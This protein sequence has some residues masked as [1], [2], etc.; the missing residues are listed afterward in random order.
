MSKKLLFGRT[1]KILLFVTL[2]F[3]VA[4]SGVFAQSV[5]PGDIVISE[6]MADPN[7]TN[8]S[9]G[10]YIELYNRRSFSINIEGYTLSDDGSDSHTI[11][12]PLNIPASGFVVLARSESPGFTPDY[13]FNSF[14]L[15]NSGDDII[16]SDAEGAEIARVNY[17]SGAVQTGVSSELSDIN[18]VDSNGQVSGSDYVESEDLI[19]NGDKGSPAEN[20]TAGSVA[21]SPSIKFLNQQKSVSEDTSSDIVT[22]LIEDPNGNQV[23]F[24]VVFVGNAS[25]AEASDLGESSPVSLTFSAD[26]SD[27][28]QLTAFTL[29][30]DGDFEGSE[31]A[32]FKLSNLSSSGSDSIASPST[33]TVTINDDDIPDVVINEFLADPPDGNAGDANGDGTRNADDDEFVEIVNNESTDIDISGWQLSDDGG[34]TI[35]HT[36]PS[37]TVLPAGRAI[38]VFGGGEPTGNFGGSIIQTT[39]SLSLSNSGGNVTLLDDQDNTVQDVTYGSEAGNDESITRDE[40]IVGSFTG[41]TSA[42]TEDGSA[43]SPGT[44]IDGTPFGSDHAIAIRGTEGWRMISSPVQSATFSDLLSEFWMQGVSGSDDDSPSADGTIFSW[45]ESGE[46]SFDAPGNMSDNLEAGKGYIVYF[47]EDDEFSTPGVQGGFPKIINTDGTENTGSVSVPVSATDGDD[48][49]VIDGEEGWNLLGNPFDTDL[50]VTAVRDALESANSSVNTNIYVWDHDG[51]G[52]NGGWVALTDGDLI[53][54]FQAFFVRF[55]SAFSDNASFNKS[56]LEANEGKEFYKDVG[57][58]FKFELELYG[59]QYFDTYSLEFT[60]DGS[61]ELDRY[62]AYKLFSLNPNSINLYSTINNNRLQKNVLPRELETNLQIPLSIDASGWTSLTFKWSSFENIPDDWDIILIDNEMNREIN[63]RTSDEYVFT[64]SA[65]ESEVNELGNS[66]NKKGLLK[67]AEQ[68]DGEPRFTL[69]VQP[70]LANADESEI[71]E[72]V[73]LNPNYPNPFNPSTTLSFE[74][75]QDAEVTLSIWNMIGQ[76]VATLVDGMVEAGTHQHTWNA[77]N[78]PSGMYIAR[79]EVGGDVFTRKMT[80]I[81]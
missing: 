49:G 72:S 74:L 5:Q 20:G 60:D 38:V 26:A 56:S 18:K 9:D 54:P 19:G 64:L 41:H 40:D 67:N 16:L 36:F 66:S 80:L 6:F 2:L 65:E 51:G 32:V 35:R 63:L 21:E 24:D 27:G 62:D 29:S 77:S 15:A 14:V 7:A 68:E 4:A 78:M 61:V 44:E 71:P 25:S 50:S 70:K 73:K 58:N 37:G 52:G 79:L 39:S 42:D 53:A 45:K 76:K 17:T 3:G 55:T 69:A 30:N 23:D 57:D 28:D 31:K 1:K 48:S 12:S 43:Y 46:G 34:S 22:V 59:D 11:S 13:A 33:A 75:A 8:D 10:E 81:K 47:F